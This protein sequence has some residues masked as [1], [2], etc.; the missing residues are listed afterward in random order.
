MVLYDIL[1]AYLSAFSMEMIVERHNAA[2]VL[3]PYTLSQQLRISFG[4]RNLSEHVW[5]EALAVKDLR[6]SNTIMIL[7][8]DSK[9]LMD[10]T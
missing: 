1:W 5:D 2:L 6:E 7:L 3:G 10:I 8:P 9:K 4:C